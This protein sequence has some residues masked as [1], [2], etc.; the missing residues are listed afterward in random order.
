MNRGPGAKEGGPSRKAFT[1]EV[2]LEL[3]LKGRVFAR[4]RPRGSITY[5]LLAFAS[6]STLVQGRAPIGAP[7][8]SRWR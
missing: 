8:L 4:W 5:I 7:Y 1:E 2:T 6:I 3:G